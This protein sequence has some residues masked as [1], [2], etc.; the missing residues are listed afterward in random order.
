M[1]LKIVK[2]ALRYGLAC[3]WCIIF[4]IFFSL[5]NTD[6]WLDFEYLHRAQLKNICIRNF[7]VSPTIGASHTSKI[8]VQIMKDVSWTYTWNLRELFCSKRRILFHYFWRPID[9]VYLFIESFPYSSRYF[10]YP[11]LDYQYWIWYLSCLWYGME[12]T[13]K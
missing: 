6:R 3:K 9:S 11:T 13:R 12:R 7:F 4:V 2:K 8:R 10:R 1:N 5:V